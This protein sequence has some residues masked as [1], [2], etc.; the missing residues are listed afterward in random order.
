MIAFNV[1]DMTVCLVQ[2]MVKT[3]LLQVMASKFHE[4]FGTNLTLVLLAIISGIG[5]L[6]S[7]LA[8]VPVAAASIVMWKAYLV[9]AEFVPEAAMGDRFTEW[10]QT[11]IPVFVGMMYGAT[12]RG[13]ATLIGSAANIVAAGVCGNEGR[14]VTFARFLR[15][16]LPIT[17]CQLAV[18][19]AYV[20]VLSKLLR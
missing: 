6:P 17:L 20:M 8:N 7:L 15:Y 13:N 18:T 1:I 19:A 10:P 2:A 3:S 4:W 14:P 9:T 16:G 11:V 12:L 5:L